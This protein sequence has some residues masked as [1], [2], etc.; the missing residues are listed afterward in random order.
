MPYAWAKVTGT[1]GEGEKSVTRSGLCD[2]RLR[3]S[4]L[5]FGAPAATR[6]ELANAPHRTILGISITIVTPTGQYFP[7]K[8]I[9]LGTNRWSFKPELALSQPIGS[10]WLF[11]LYAGIWMFTKNNAYYPASSIRT[12]DVM[13]SFQ[14]HL[15]YNISARFWAAFDCTY[16]TGGESSVDGNAMND[17]QSNSRIGATMVLPVGKRHSVKA[18]YSTGAIIRSGANFTSVSIGW[19]TIFLGKSEKAKP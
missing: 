9:N 8:L 19:Q 18:A 4:F 17:R 13:G 7:G 2:I 14:S 5:F 11:D 6:A 15:S 10:R 16:Y 1:V 12:Q 3:C